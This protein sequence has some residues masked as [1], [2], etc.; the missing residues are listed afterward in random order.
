MHGYL[1]S[2]AA[3]N[4]AN[5]WRSRALQ[6]E[7]DHDAVQAPNFPF[8]I[9]EPP[10]G[11]PTQFAGLRV[12]YAS[13]VKELSLVAE[14]DAPSG[15]GGVLKVRKGGSNYAVYLVETTD[16][17]ASSVRIRTSTGTKSIRLKT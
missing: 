10:S 9:S 17:N 12:F 7:I 5:R 8:P 1:V 15:M 6:F 14:G 2:F 16:P 3:D 11:F 4:S 13:A